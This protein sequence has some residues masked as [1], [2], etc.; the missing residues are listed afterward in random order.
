MSILFWNIILN[1]NTIYQYVE[2]KILTQCLLLESTFV[3]P[4]P[5]STRPTGSKRLLRRKR[6]KYKYSQKL[7]YGEPIMFFLQ[8]E[9]WKWPLFGKL[10]F[11][12][13]ELFKKIVDMIT[14]YIFK[15]AR[16]KNNSFIVWKTCKSFSFEIYLRCIV[17]WL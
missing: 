7:G 1:Y 8:L 16:W 9:I 15:E 2:N 17:V 5:S 13:Q 4:G 6:K 10:K 12:V 11:V 3:K 14:Q